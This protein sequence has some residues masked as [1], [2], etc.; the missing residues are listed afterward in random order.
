LDDAFSS[1]CKIIYL[2]VIAIEVTPGII[3][4]EVITLLIIL[5]KDGIIGTLADSPT[6]RQISFEGEELT[7]GIVYNC[8]IMYRSLD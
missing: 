5:E 1:F 3:F 7:R 4:S 8:C 6:S 2:F